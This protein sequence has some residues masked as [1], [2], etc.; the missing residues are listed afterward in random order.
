MSNVVN[1]DEQRPHY[2][3]MCSCLNCK[4]EWVGVV[5]MTATVLECPSC[6]A[7]RGAMFSAREVRL[8][9]ALEQVATGRAPNENSRVNWDIAKD[10][11]LRALEAEGWGIIRKS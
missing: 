11:A 6:H 7:M 2:S 5:P 3:G 8:I 1:L 4:H 10:I 9:R